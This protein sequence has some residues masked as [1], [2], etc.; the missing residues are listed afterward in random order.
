MRAGR[1]RTFGGG[2]ARV[3]R[4]QASAP[5]KL[6]L[7]GDYA[8]LDGAPALVVAMN[9]RARVMLDSADGAGVEVTAPDLGITSA[10]A[11]VDAAGKLEWNTVADAA[12][13]GLV[14]Q[15]WNA[16]AGIGLA[17]RGGLDLTLD[18]SGFFAATPTGRRKLG[19]G[20]SAALTVALAAALVR[21]SGQ[22][23]A[24]TPAWLARL[25]AWHGA[26]QGGRGSGVDIAA[27]LSGG[28]LTYRRGMPGAAPA[29]S[30]AS[31]PPAG[32]QYLFVW[33]QEAV[34]TAG[35]L[36]HLAAWRQTHPADYAARM[37]E[38]CQ[39]A[40]SAPTAL[41]GDAAGFVALVAAY[42]AALSRLERASGLAIF[43]PAQRELA[44]LAAHAGA[45]FKPCGAGG[46]FGVVVADGA[47]QLERVRRAM[48]AAG[49]H[50]EGLAVDPQGV[51]CDVSF[52]HSGS[53]SH[54]AAGQG[55]D[56]P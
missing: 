27:S 17:P 40:E 50:A 12:R 23:F 44:A 54:G 30:S 56:F 38:L 39:L 45:A 28:A 2:A 33:S 8:V 25:V 36:A 6:V 10:S 13:L 35:Q 34:S 4:I 3:T 5:G 55:G 31:W 42:A 29:S 51:Q 24:A 21:A 47:P 43:S 32:A 46:D 19:L 37:G 49:L 22:G 7:L 18:T 20:S 41:H 16:L 26:W 52:M 9:R 11:S 14:T 1:W 48:M 15:V 53:P